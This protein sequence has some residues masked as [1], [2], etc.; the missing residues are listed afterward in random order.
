MNRH[1]PRPQGDFQEAF[2]LFGVPLWVLPAVE[3][4]GPQPPPGRT[5]VPRHRPPRGIPASRHPGI[6]ASR[7]GS[8]CSRR[9]LLAAGAMGMGSGLGRGPGRPKVHP[10][11]GDRHR[12]PLGA[13]LARRVAHI[14]TGRGPPPVSAALHLA[15][16]RAHASR[17]EA[18]VAS[19]ARATWKRHGARR[20]RP[21]REVQSLLHLS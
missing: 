15:P 13:A 6:P 21:P 3:L 14:P 2:R 5:R 4:P 8:S 1:A 18:R 11:G 7:Q 12:G 20:R 19:R 10:R 9:S 16:A 17:V